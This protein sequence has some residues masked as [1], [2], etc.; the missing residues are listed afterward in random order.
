MSRPP[1][2]AGKQHIAP[3]TNIRYSG[4]LHEN[5]RLTVRQVNNKLGGTMAGTRGILLRMAKD[6]LISS[7]Q[8]KNG[9]WMFWLE[10]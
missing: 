7:E 9:Q 6:D 4:A 10:E 1:G 5:G 8:I 2:K 3:L